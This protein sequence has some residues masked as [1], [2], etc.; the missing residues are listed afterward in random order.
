MA[1]LVFYGW[2][3][4]GVYQ[5]VSGPALTAEGRLTGTVTLTLTNTEAAN[6]SALG[7][8][9]FDVMGPGDVKGLSSRSITRAVPTHGAAD[10]E[11]DKCVFV[12]LSAADLP[13]R[14]TPMLAN[15]L[16]LQPWLA[17]VVGT[18]DEVKLLPGSMVTLAGSVLVA[19]D[20]AKSA[21]WAHVQEEAGHPDHGIARLLSER[22]LLPLTEY[23]AAVVPA[24]S[25]VG[26]PAWTKQMPS[27][28]LPLYYSW[29][30]RTGQAGDFAS[31]AGRLKPSTAAAEL[32]RAPM[33]YLP[34]P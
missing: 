10:A 26:Q 1:D 25:E 18:T 2:H 6:D 19:H 15:G 3:R 30:F 5:A 7:S 17:L 9:P 33:R 32:G 16:V 27:V 11:E 21:R 13:W 34:I 31:L 20:L 8:V 29:R 14:Y 28:T 22:P 24:F 23:V 4:S 12:E